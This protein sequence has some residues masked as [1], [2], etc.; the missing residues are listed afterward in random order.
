[1]LTSFIGASFSLDCVCQAEPF[2]DW[3]AAERA[4]FSSARL[5]ILTALAGLQAQARDFAGAVETA[6]RLTALDPY[7]EESNRLLMELLAASGQRGLALIEH[8]R[9]ARIL[10]EELQVAP[11]ATTRALAEKIRRD[12]PIKLQG[13]AFAEREAAA[14]T[15]APRFQYTSPDRAAIAILPFANLSGEPGQDHLAQSL[16]EDVAATLVRGKMAVRRYH[17]R[18]HT[19][20]PA[21]IYV[22]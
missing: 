12:R 18:E 5:R 9:V 21:R 3:V 7:G 16:T 15:P 8:A 1:M 11:D 6:R 17:A 20:R 10:R 2:E 4:R 14:T 19:R 22:G 13:S